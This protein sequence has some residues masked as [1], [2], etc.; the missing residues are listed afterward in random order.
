MNPK[1]IENWLNAKLGIPED[2][3]SAQETLN[4]VNG[5]NAMLA[6]I[7]QQ[8]AWTESEIIK[9]TL[10]H[11]RDDIINKHLKMTKEN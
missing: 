7:D 10:E 8:I 6:E 5:V 11:V 3:V 4:Y 2:A 9:M 1:R